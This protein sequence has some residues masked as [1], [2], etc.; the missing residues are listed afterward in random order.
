MTFA[1]STGG[2]FLADDMA[3]MLV[4]YMKRRGPWFQVGDA[5]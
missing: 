1:P 3:A 5:L 4:G 2:S